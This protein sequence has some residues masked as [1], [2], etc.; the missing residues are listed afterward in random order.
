MVSSRTCLIRAAIAAVSPSSTA[1]RRFS[2]KGS[3]SRATLLM[4]FPFLTSV[5][6]EIGVAR[7]PFLVA[8]HQQPRLFERHALGAQRRLGDLVARVRQA[9]EAALRTRA[10]R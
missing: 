4:A 9:A 5:L 2:I 3:T 10:T 8:P 1:A 6:F 7:Q